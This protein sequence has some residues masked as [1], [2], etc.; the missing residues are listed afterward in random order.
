MEQILL[1]PNIQR[2]INKKGGC[3]CTGRCV[4]YCPCQS[5]NNKCSK[6][7]HNGNNCENC[8]VDIDHPPSQTLPPSQTS[9]PHTPSLIQESII[10]ERDITEP[11]GFNEFD[12]SSITDW[13]KKYTPCVII[14]PNEFKLV[15]ISSGNHKCGICHTYKITSQEFTKAKE[16]MRH[17]CTDKLRCTGNCNF[18][19]LHKEGQNKEKVE[20]KAI[21]AIQNENKR[22]LQELKSQMRK[23]EDDK[24]R[25]EI[26]EHLSVRNTVQASSTSTSKTI[27][28]STDYNGNP[29]LMSTV[30]SIAQTKKNEYIPAN[31][32]LKAIYKVNPTS[33]LQTP[34]EYLELLNSNVED[35]SKDEDIF[36][37]EEIEKIIQKKTIQQELLNNQITLLVSKKKRM[38]ELIAHTIP[39]EQLTPEDHYFMYQR[40]K[41]MKEMQE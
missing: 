30:K 25:A 1:T 36:D 24:S 17:F 4:R 37:I 35:G 39:N 14:S 8:Q 20:E 21:K 16:R 41:R 19:D 29:L 32:M 34:R 38:E 12:F 31:K 11:K 18:P 28:S 22:K 9:P 3:D 40:L 6:F 13:R 23:E 27:I 5:L 2:K 33:S 15:S 10:V 7:C 26:L